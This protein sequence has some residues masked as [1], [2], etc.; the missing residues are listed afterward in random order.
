MGVGMQRVEV[1][2][3]KGQKLTPAEWQRLLRLLFGSSARSAG[4]IR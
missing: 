3:K 2:L 4:N 1:V